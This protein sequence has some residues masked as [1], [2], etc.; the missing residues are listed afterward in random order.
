M[1]DF[2]ELAKSPSVRLKTPVAASIFDLFEF[3]QQYV[4]RPRFESLPRGSE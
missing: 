3:I 1:T 2:T 4:S